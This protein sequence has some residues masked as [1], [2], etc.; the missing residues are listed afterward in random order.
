MRL[1]ML[2]MTRGKLYAHNFLPINPVDEAA[3]SNGW[4]AKEANGDPLWSGDTRKSSRC[5]N[6]GLHEV[7]MLFLVFFQKH[8]VASHDSKLLLSVNLFQNSPY[9]FVQK[10]NPSI[11]AVFFR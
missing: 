6:K 5:G 1:E 2:C 3:L 7:L 9:I 10:C 8:R 11:N 4:L